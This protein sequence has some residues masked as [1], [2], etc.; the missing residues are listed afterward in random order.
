MFILVT[1]R[2]MATKV[3]IG[4]VLLLGLTLM[5]AFAGESLGLVAYE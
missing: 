4:I 5:L 2:M 1:A 3:L